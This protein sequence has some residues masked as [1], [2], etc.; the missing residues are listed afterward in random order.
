MYIRHGKQRTHN[1]CP[2]KEIFRAFV[3]RGPDRASGYMPYGIS[4]Q[5]YAVVLFGFAISTTMEY[6][7]C[8]T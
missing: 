1:S 2:N 8:R 3:F 4:M 7:T 6:F 5:S